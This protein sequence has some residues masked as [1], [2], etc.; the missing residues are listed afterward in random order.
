MNL[1]DDPL[2]KNI[3]AAAAERGQSDLMRND[4]MNR[5]HKAFVEKI[6]E[7]L[8]QPA[9]EPSATCGT[10]H[11]VQSNDKAIMRE[12]LNPSYERSMMDMV[13]II[14][15]QTGASCNPVKQ[16]KEQL[17]NLL[18]KQKEIGAS[19]SAELL[20]LAKDLGVELK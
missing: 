10:G 6:K 5:D 15:G 9:V 7:H 3:M 13:I 19:P 2:A 14:G 4:A 17:T 18:G 8:L 1:F 12:M 11:V 20:K 16:A